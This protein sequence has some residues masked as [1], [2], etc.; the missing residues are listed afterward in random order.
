MASSLCLICGLHQSLNSSDNSCVRANVSE[1]WCC[2]EVNRAARRKKSVVVRRARA[3]GN[4]DAPS[5]RSPCGFVFIE[6]FHNPSLM[7]LRASE[8]LP[9][10]QELCTATCRTYNGFSGANDNSEAFWQGTSR[11]TMMA[12]YPFLWKSGPKATRWRLREADA[13]TPRQ[14]ASGQSRV[15]QSQ[16]TGR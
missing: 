11:E 6:N 10:I 12:P 15:P 1:N 16:P 8:E 13:E 14:G 9:S 4:D 5:Q 7:H 3:S 2:R